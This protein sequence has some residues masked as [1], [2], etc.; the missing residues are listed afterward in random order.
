[1]TRIV[2]KIALPLLLTAFA[3]PALAA[4]RQPDA[5][6]SGYDVIRSGDL[7]QAAQML[8]EARETGKSDPFQLLNLAY[9]MQKQGR[10][11]EAADVYKQI[12]Q[13]DQNPYAQMASGDARR[14]KSIARDG[15]AYLDKAE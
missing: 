10:T 1:M 11:D 4:D 6:A 3:G 13:L 5:D 9:V 12:L 7:D 14:V 2:L 15:L 8:G